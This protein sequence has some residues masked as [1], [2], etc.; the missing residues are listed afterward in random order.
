MCFALDFQQ[1]MS[2]NNGPINYKKAATL[3]A[4]HWEQLT[5]DEKGEWKEK[6]L[7]TQSSEVAIEGMPSKKAER[8]KLNCLM[9]SIDSVEAL[10]VKAQ[11][12]YETMVDEI[13]TMV[14]DAGDLR[15]ELRGSLET[16]LASNQIVYFRT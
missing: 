9:Q 5:D 7:K 11:Q 10:R 15:G 16:Y 14:T 1:R 3:A 13:K 12:E 8:K 6:A 2:K 4:P